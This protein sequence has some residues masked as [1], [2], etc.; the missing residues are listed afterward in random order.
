MLVAPIAQRKVEHRLVLEHVSATLGLG[1]LEDPLERTAGLAEQVAE[2]ARQSHGVDVKRPGRA[3]DRHAVQTAAEPVGRLQQGHVLAELGQSSRRGE[4]GEAATHHHDSRHA[5]RLRG[6][7][8][9][10]T[11]C[12]ADERHRSTT[13]MSP[14]SSA[15]LTMLLLNGSGEVLTASRMPDLTLCEARGLLLREPA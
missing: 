15:V 7:A 4:T 5:R 6:D 10:P 9:S 12:L 14:T 13:V 8:P 2:H 11:P 1:H 3:V